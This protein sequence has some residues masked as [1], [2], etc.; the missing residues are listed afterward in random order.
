VTVAVNWAL[1][2][3]A[4]TVTLAGTLTLALALDKVTANPPV[5]AA[6]FSVAVQEEVPGAFTLAGVQS[7][8]LNDTGGGGWRT[9]IVPP[10]PEAGSR[11]AAAFVTTTPLS[12][13]GRLVLAVLPAILKANLAIVPIPMLEVPPQSMQVMDPLPP[14]HCRLLPAAEAAESMVAATL[15]MSGAEYPIVHCKPDG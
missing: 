5:E 4:A 12:A 8:V 13:T 10:V 14:A 2:D 3:P 9:V 7:R 1:L 11:I 6:S 15:A